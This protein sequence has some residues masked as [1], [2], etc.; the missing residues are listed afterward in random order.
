MNGHHLSLL[1][2]CKFVVFD[3]PLFIGRSY[4]LATWKSV[5]TFTFELEIASV[6]YFHN[7]VKIEEEQLSELADNVTIYVK[8]IIDN[9]AFSIKYQ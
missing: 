1:C 8:F 5:C 3:S 7:S 4:F 2:V 9:T 6:P